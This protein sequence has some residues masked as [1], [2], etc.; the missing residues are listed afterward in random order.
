[1][2]PTMAGHHNEQTDFPFFI[3]MLSIVSCLAYAY[4]KHSYGACDDTPYA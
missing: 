2:V 1:M 3:L 4:R